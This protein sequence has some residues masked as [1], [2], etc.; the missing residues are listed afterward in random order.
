MGEHETR[1]VRTEF[2]A[3]DKGLRGQLSQISGAFAHAG[4]QTEG[5]RDRIRDFRKEQGLTTVAV[6]GLGYGIGSVFERI[7]EENAEFGRA[8]KGIAGV[9][10]G[11]LKFD[12][13]TTEVNRYTRSLALAKD[14]TEELEHTAG[15]FNLQFTDVAEVYKKTALAAG[16]MGLSQKQVME[17]T[18]KTSASAARFQIQGGDAVNTVVRALRT[19]G[20]RG[21]DE[22]SISLD[23]LLKRMGNLK[24]MNQEQR[25]GAIQKALGGSV[26]IADVMAGGIGGA[27]SRARMVIGET[28]RDLTSPVFKEVATRLESWV[29]HLREAR[30]GAK[31]LID[32]FSGKLLSAF[33]TLA[34]ITSTLK[35]H[36]M[37]IG[38]VVAGMKVGG[39]LTGIAGALGSAGGAL[40]G[41]GPL[42]YLGGK[43]GGLGG[44]AGSLGALAPALGGIVTA[45]ALASIALKGVYDEWQGRKKQAADLG[46]FFSEMGK[47]A[48]T[49]QYMQ[50]HLGL[51]SD[52][53]QAG[54]DFAATH[55]AA[56][57][58][59]LKAKGLFENGALA[60]EKFNGVVDSMSDDV[61]KKFAESL[62]LKGLGDVSSGM[63]GAA[64]TEL[65]Q[66]TYKPVVAGAGADDA[67]RKFAKQVV[68]N[69]FTGGIHVTW[70]NEETDPDRVFVR[71][72]DHIENYTSRRTQAVT[73][74]PLSE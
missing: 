22:F 30:A 8:T 13:G 29:K 70:K 60:V 16:S 53:A 41:G 44:I 68:N 2:T 20:V 54:K 11:A 42:G 39:L 57:A 1:E 45:A 74:D 19:G 9:L 37:S 56:A 64:A 62:G 71:F 4:H 69:N 67:N 34:D 72:I 10:S 14:V 46:G 6:L 66:K 25:F 32:E 63:L 35:E 52:Q 26:E 38:A 55:A 58:E 23:R 43:L 24:K 33:K 51:S 7:K 15:R 3:E 36:W 59:I 17:L 47:V 18:E 48:E 40:G 49:Q 31:P 5:L 61:R 27:V 65:F 73:A 12:E 28:L 50:K 21:T